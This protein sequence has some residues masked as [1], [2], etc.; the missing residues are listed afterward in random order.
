MS[1]NLGIGEYRKKD[2][3]EILNISEDKDNMDETW[4]EWKANKR[5]AILRFEQMGFKAVDIIV[6]PK[7]LVKFCRK[8][9]LPINGKSRSEFVTFKMSE[10]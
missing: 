1:L 9:G 4:E 3:Q 2:Y 7:E 6:T 5:K 10:E 8:N